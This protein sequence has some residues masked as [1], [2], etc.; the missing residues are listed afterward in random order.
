M[1]LAERDAAGDEVLREVR[2]E[3][4][5]IRGRR[6]EAGLVEFECGRCGRQRV[7]AGEDMVHCIEDRGLVLLEIAVVREG[8]GLQRRKE[9]DEV[10]N[11][12]TRLP[13]GELRDVRVSLLRHEAAPRPELRPGTDEPDLYGG[14]VDDLLPERA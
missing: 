10:S 2:G 1:G 7:E 9:C 5:G 13:A 8:Q 4:A 12:S 11:H 6:L 3:V 14:P